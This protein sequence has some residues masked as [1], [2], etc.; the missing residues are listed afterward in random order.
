VQGV[1]TFIKADRAQAVRRAYLVRA[2]ETLAI[3]WVV[4]ERSGVEERNLK[5]PKKG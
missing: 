3:M 5:Q 1:E 4:V 2:S